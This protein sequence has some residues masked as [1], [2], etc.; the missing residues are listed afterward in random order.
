MI[1]RLLIITITII[2][3]AIIVFWLFFMPGRC[4]K[5]WG[6]QPRTMPELITDKELAK[7]KSQLERI[8]GFCAQ[9]LSTK[10]MS[11][12]S[13][14]CISSISFDQSTKWPNENK[15]PKGFNP[16]LWLRVGK[17]PGLSLNKIHEKG[18]TGKGVSVAVIDKPGS[19][20]H[21]QLW[22]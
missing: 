5:E 1:K 20:H 9:D 21:K 19:V 11:Q 12:V 8:W 4:P 15:L 16:D 17:Y 7:H 18:I 3:A 13:L 22:E 14:E 6:I 10:D 2:A